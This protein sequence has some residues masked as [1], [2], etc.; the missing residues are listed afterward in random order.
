MALANLGRDDEAFA[1]ARRAADQSDPAGMFC[2]SQLYFLGKGTAKD[3]D[4]SLAWCTRAA[5]AGERRAAFNLGA[6]H[7]TKDL[8]LSIRWYQRAVDAGHPAAAFNLAMIFA[9]EPAPL[10][11]E[12]RATELFLQAAHGGYPVART[13]MG[14]AQRQLESNRELAVWMLSVAAS[15]DPKLAQ[16]LHR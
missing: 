13:L 15:L 5:E 1:E 7:A 16:A 12:S 8:T 11:N 10:K 6:L 9:T 3:P 14:I 2:L 4:Q